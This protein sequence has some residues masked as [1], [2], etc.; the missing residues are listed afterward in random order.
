[1]FQRSVGPR[2]YGRQLTQR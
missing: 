2:S 1:M